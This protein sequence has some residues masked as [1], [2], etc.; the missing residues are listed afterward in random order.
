MSCTSSSGVSNKNIHI[1]FIL[2]GKKKIK[3]FLHPM[4]AHTRTSLARREADLGLISPYTYERVGPH[5]YEFGSLEPESSRNREPDSYVYG[6]PNNHYL[7]K[8][9]LL[10]FGLVRYVCSWQQ[11]LSYIKD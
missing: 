5:T 3:R 9:S 1:I 8:K 11:T 4:A 6:S 7:K 10:T 2:K